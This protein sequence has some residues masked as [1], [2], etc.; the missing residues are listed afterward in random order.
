RSILDLTQVCINEIMIHRKDMFTLDA[1]EPVQ[2][3]IDKALKSPYTRIP[4]WKDNPDNIIGVLHTK[5]LLRA[6]RSHKGNHDHIDIQ[7]IGKNP[8][9][10]PESTT[11]FEQLHMFRE[12]KSHFALVV[13]EYG[14]LLGMLTLEDILEEIV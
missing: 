11:L 2:D 1:N 10:A 7:S 13:D 9:F 8:W 14:A 6:V 5:N 12:H 3:I 4:L